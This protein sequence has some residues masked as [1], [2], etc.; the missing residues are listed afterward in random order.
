LT[1][2]ATALL[3]ILALAMTLVPAQSGPVRTP[4]RRPPAFDHIFVVL[5]ENEDF[6]QIVDNPQAPFIN[7]LIRNNFLERHYL[8]LDHGSLP[9]YLG[10]VSGSEQKQ[11]IGDPPGD[12]RPDWMARPPTCAITGGSPS[13]L[14]DTIES[15]GKTW[16]GYFQSMGAP[17]RWQSKSALYDVIHNPF[18]YFASVE[19]G[20]GQSSARCIRDD[21]DMFQDPQH[22]LAVD[23]RQAA[24]TPNFL[25]MVPNN[26]YSMHDG[27]IQ[28]G[29]R[30]LRDIL[31]GAN[32]TG[33]NGAG[34]NLFASPAWMSTRSI[35]YVVWDENSGTQG[36]QVPAIEV[37]NW[38]N[39][40]GG[41]SETFADHYSL[42]RTW[43][44]AWGLPPIQHG[45]GDDIAGPMLDAFTL[46]DGLPAVGRLPSPHLEVFAQARVRVRSRDGPV[47]VLALTDGQ[48]QAVLRLEMDRA[49]LL[50]LAN[51][52][53][54][55]STASRQA[56][57]SGWHT[58]GLHLFA[59]G[60]LG[61]C[62]VWYDGVPVSELTDDGHCS[63]GINPVA[64]YAGGSAAAEISGVALGTGPL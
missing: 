6:A 2:P 8:A 11:F 42:L 7:E 27:S 15:A 44:A 61:S 60:S 3:G 12:C 34:V 37:G 39:G 23:L 32:S 48:G 36:N 31:T 33:Q 28:A 9:D 18:V 53:T 22:S 57:G 24:T 49:G 29:D 17:C 26:V 14:A 10:L 50:R 47:P 30:F 38:V 20:A 16:R 43:E 5:E 45:S 13:N 4:V 46:V 59:Q 52:V 62:E 35:L 56:F 21:V 64:G 40:P 1:R 63:T 54:G 25:F 51:G 55:L 41:R 19:G 58:V